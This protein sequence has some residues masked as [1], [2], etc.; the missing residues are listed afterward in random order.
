MG[1]P[2]A[3][4]RA[5]LFPFYGIL[6][7]MK[8][9]PLGNLDLPVTFGSRTNYRT[10]TLTF[11]VVYWKGA[12]H[13]IL[14]CPAY[15]KFMAVPNY[16]YLKLKLP[17]PNGVITRSGS[18]K[19]DYASSREHFDLATT[20]ANSAELSQLHVT[21]AECRPDPSKPSHAPTFISTEETKPSHASK[22]TATK[23]RP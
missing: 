14:G 11:E 7:G 23:S 1:T 4:L 3:C 18:F 9:Y 22:P 15:T 19:K 21:T 20:A 6:P 12:Y 5:S 10:E 17:G 2:W 16:T 13:A 8:A